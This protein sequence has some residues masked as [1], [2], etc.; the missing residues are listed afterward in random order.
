MQTSEPQVAEVEHM[1]LTTSPQDWLLKCLKKIAY[2]KRSI[3]QLGFLTRNF[4]L[5]FLIIASGFK[6][7]LFIFYLAL[8]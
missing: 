3:F 5:N 1:N 8:Y 2:S 6:F 4:I 7:Y